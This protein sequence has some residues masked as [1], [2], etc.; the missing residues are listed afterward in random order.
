MQNIFS[1]DGVIL[2]TGFNEQGKDHEAILDKVLR[3]RRQE[4]LRLKKVSVSLDA[5]AFH[6]LCK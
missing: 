3:V 6:S 4:N 5:P 2:I 1:K